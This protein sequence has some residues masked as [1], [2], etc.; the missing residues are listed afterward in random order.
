M[1]WF[2]HQTLAGVADYSRKMGY[3]RQ[4]RFVH[5]FFGLWT[6]L[7]SQIWQTSESSEK[8]RRHMYYFFHLATYESLKKMALRQKQLNASINTSGTTKV[9]DSMPPQPPN[10]RSVFG[11]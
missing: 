1:H 4:Y 8:S 10:K 9:P 7:R 11:I 3:C 5:D 2:S 6:V